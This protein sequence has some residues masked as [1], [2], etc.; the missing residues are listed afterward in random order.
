VIG[1]TAGAAVRIYLR[2]MFSALAQYLFSFFAPPPPAKKS[3]GWSL[4]QTPTQRRYGRGC[5]F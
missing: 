1:L 4:V 2:T 3:I 5:H